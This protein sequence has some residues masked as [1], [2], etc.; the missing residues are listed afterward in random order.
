MPEFTLATLSPAR[1]AARP[2]AMR[3]AQP[4]PDRACTRGMLRARQ[5][6]W[7][8]ALV[9]VAACAP[10]PPKPAAPPPA[11]APPYVRVGLEPMPYAEAIQA[12]AIDLAGQLR[13]LDANTR[14]PPAQPPASQ[15]SATPPAV[16][17]PAEPA[18]RL[19]VIDPFIDAQT[20]FGTDATRRL[21]QDLGTRMAEAA[22][23]LQTEPMTPGNL[24]GSDF[25]MSGAIS[26]DPRDN[27]PSTRLYRILVSLVNARTGA[28]VAKAAAWLSERSLDMTPLA[29]FQES[30]LYLNDRHTASLLNTVRLPVGHESDSRYY[31][32]LPVSAVLADAQRAFADGQYTD[33][34]AAYQRAEALPEGKSMKTYSG[35]YVTQRKLGKAADAERAFDQLLKVALDEDRLAIRFLFRVNSIDFVADAALAEQYRM[36]IRLMA[37]EFVQRNTCLDILGHSSRTG[38]DAYN[39][40]LSLRRAEAVR[41]QLRTAHAGTA[42]LTRA[43]GRGS[44]E[45]LV[46]SGTD[47]ARD[48]VDRRVEL[49]TISC[50]VSR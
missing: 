30:P 5:V 19:A 7:M 24:V 22:E 47:D 45:N 32:H 49:R 15:A 9:G 2:P 10:A 38:T 23:R 21:Q 25:V 48:A 29:S 43:V 4:L 42:A 37:Q 26:F 33:A 1:P 13:A 6:L 36:W 17:A 40:M 28:L 50:P 41:Q 12:I 14:P 34:L 18:T 20:G 35:M 8:L 31:Q 46:G 27:D 39:D 11:P 44:R 16:R 3:P